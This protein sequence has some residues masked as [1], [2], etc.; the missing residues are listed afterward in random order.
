MDI[1]K[2]GAAPPFAIT[3][4]GPPRRDCRSAAQARREAEARA[5]YDDD[6]RQ[7]L[8]E[9]EAVRCGVWPSFVGGRR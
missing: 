7:R 2:L 9:A 5:A 8:A 3:P 1:T 4:A 6:Y